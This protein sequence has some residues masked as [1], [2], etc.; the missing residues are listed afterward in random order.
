[1]SYSF[2][3]VY[4]QG[5]LAYRDLCSRFFARCAPGSYP[6]TARQSRLSRCEATPLP[7]NQRD[8]PYQQGGRRLQRNFLT[9]LRPL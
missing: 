2:R 4:R 3:I 5:L 8:G 1:M 6:G 7:L 9:S